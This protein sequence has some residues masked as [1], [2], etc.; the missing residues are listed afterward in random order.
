MAEARRGG[1]ASVSIAWL[2]GGRAAIAVGAIALA[3]VLALPA[4]PA[5]ARDGSP[6]G[7][8]QKS[9]TSNNND[10][11]NGGSSAASAVNAVSPAS[12]ASV[13]ASP[14]AAT[15]AGGEGNFGSPGG[16]TAA[17]PGVGGN[18][19]SGGGGN[20][21]PLGGNGSPHAPHLGFSFS[22][23]SASV[24]ATVPLGGHHPAEHPSDR[25]MHPIL[26]IP[27]EHGGHSLSHALSYG[28][29][30][31][32]AL[33]GGSPALTN[34]LIH[35]VTSTFSDHF[36]HNLGN[37]LRMQEPGGMHLLTAPG[38]SAA[39][40]SD[41]AAR[42]MQAKHAIATAA[43]TPPG[44]T[45]ATTGVGNRAPAAIVS[46]R[47]AGISA[48]ALEARMFTVPAPGETRYV[49][50]E[51][52]VGA[53][54]G[55]STEQIADIARRNGLAPVAGGTFAS[56][57]LTLQRWRI[58][59]DRPIGDVI[60]ALQGETGLQSAQPNFRFA[61][62][63]AAGYSQ[64]P[65]DGFSVQYAPEKLH[66][67]QAHRL[68]TGGGVIVAVIDTGIDRAHPE[69]AGAILASF[70]AIGAQE[71]PDAHGTAIAGAIVAHGRLV[72][73]APGVRLLAIRAF[74]TAGPDAEATTMTIV[75]SIEWAVAHGA[76]V[77][78]M[79]FAGARDPL[80]SRALADARRHGIVLVAAAGNAGP[81]SPPLYPAAD[82]NVIAVSATDI[83]DH[84][85]DV[86]NR[87]RQ[88][89]IAAPGVD[90]LLPAPHARYQIA[91]GTSF[92]AAHVAG[93]AALM[94]AKNPRL[95]PD[96]VR[97]GLTAT[98]RD[99][100]P[101]GRDDMFGAGLADA[102]KAVVAATHGS[103]Q[104]VATVGATAK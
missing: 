4:G 99:L 7:G 31:T 36:V 94:L 77:I 83:D 30:G 21:I 90:V 65:A 43:A 10:E 34:R 81:S 63:Q 42:L 32:P 16:A 3:A 85:L 72:G 93:I 56:S 20:A 11:D 73:V 25:I 47:F 29:T 104:T 5:A 12:P 17:G 74:S 84:L 28:E 62:A 38:G 66:L 8:H 78:N 23:E 67:A 27:F 68:S 97:A 24:S 102:Y 87:G 88:I 59:D 57:G 95:T 41:L 79:S 96:E 33:F 40:P 89:A 52:V 70:D 82:A 98:A 39:G 61:L 9:S 6:H 19:S 2:L 71:P 103:P 14:G 86:A 18:R 44:A 22:N 13:S 80:I 45:A 48:N 26:A 35:S 55:L 100:G 1:A 50:N 64:Q 54:A 69:L 76:R 60:R 53:P 46:N 75:R 91:T 92:A 15:S 37:S 51:I 49:T 101:K 58:T